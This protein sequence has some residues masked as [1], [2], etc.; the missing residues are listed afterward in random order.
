MSPMSLAPIERIQDFILPPEAEEV[1]DHLTEDGEARF[2][3]EIFQ[4]LLSA[5]AKGDFR[6]VLDVV[7]AWYRTLLMRQHPQYEETVRWARRGGSGQTYPAEDV[8][9]RFSS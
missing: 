9:E 6:P 2:G 1:F 8:V 7:E 3:R 5:Q 4:A